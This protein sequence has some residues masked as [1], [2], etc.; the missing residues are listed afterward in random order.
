MKVNHIELTETNIE[1]CFRFPAPPEGVELHKASDALL[2]QHGLPHRPDPKKFPAAARAWLQAMSKI[3][4]FV[5]PN[6]MVESKLLHGLPEPITTQNPPIL[7]PNL[8]PIEFQLSWSGLISNAFSSYTQVWGTWVVPAVSLPA[9]GKGSFHSALWVGLYDHSDYYDCPIFQ[10]GTNQSVSGSDHAYN[11][12]IEWYPAAQLILDG[13]EGQQS[14]PVLPG[15]EIMVSLE[16]IGNT[17]G[18]INM[19]NLTTGVAINPI[20]MTPPTTDAHGTPIN[21]VVP[22]K[23]AVWVME[24]PCD[25]NTPTALADFGQAVM[26]AIGAVYE[27]PNNEKGNKLEVGPNDEVTLLYMHANDG[28]TILAEAALWLPGGLTMTFVGGNKPNP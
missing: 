5:S 15:Q 18:I 24:R 26:T 4:R 16:T 20:C 25:A 11:A 6:L 12:W 10:A 9:G 28:L 23:Q 13:S 7:G 17:G 27:N 1:H 2:S 8:P 21:P 3:K 19:A 14:F 22:S